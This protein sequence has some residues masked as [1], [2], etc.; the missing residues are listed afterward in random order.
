MT[1]YAGD[2]NDYVVSALAANPSA[3]LS[4]PQ[5]F[6]QTAISPPESGYP[7]QQSNEYGYTKIW[8][9]Y[10]NSVAGTSTLTVSMTPYYIGNSPPTNTVSLP[11]V[12]PLNN[13]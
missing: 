7:P 10:T 4:T 5:T 13:W 3:P 12:Q 2:N 6:N 8:T 11:A 1:V 9:S